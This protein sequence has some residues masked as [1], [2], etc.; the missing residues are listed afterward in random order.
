MFFV[1]E[2]VNKVIITVME[3]L[4]GQFSQTVVIEE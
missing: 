3:F 4:L 1:A 2:R